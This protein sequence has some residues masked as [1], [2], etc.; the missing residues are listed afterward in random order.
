MDAK[1]LVITPGLVDMHVHFREPGFEYKED[2]ESGSRSAAAGGFTTVACMPNTDPVL[3]NEA[4]VARVIRRGRDAGHCRMYPIAAITK[5]QRGKAL[6]EMIWLREAGAVGF[7]DDGRPVES[8]RVMRRALEYAQVTG[9]PI[10]DTT[11]GFR[12]IRRSLLESCGFERIRAN[13]Y[14]FQIELNY[15]FVKAGAR[16][17]EIPF[18][19][20]DRVHGVE[21]DLGR[22]QTSMQQRLLSPTRPPVAPDT[23]GLH[24]GGA[25]HGMSNSGSTQPTTSRT[26]SISLNSPTSP[27]PSPKALSSASSPPSPAATPACAPL[28]VPSAWAGPPNRQL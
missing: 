8:S 19:F 1:G 14:A 5:D 4:L 25:E 18:F 6:T 13:G 26:P 28:A 22:C 23:T 10:S 3:D 24:E 27:H 12:C 16:I 21:V 7:S 15:R 20:L 17:R 2:I 9:L 11:G